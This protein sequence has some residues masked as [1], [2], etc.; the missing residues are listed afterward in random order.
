MLVVFQF[1]KFLMYNDLLFLQ[2]EERNGLKLGSFHYHYLLDGKIIAVEVMDLLPE[3]I[4]SKYF[5]YDPQ[6]EFLTLGT[7][8]TLR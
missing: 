3:F 6:Y 7:Y 1:A 2:E 4:S 8:S 5:I